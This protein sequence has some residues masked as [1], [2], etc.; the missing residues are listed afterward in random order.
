MPVKLGLNFNLSKPLNVRK[1][2]PNRLHAL[3]FSILPQSISEKTHQKAIK[4]FTT[5]FKGFF[6]GKERP[7]SR[8][9][10]DVT[11]LDDSLFPYFSQGLILERKTLSIDSV[12]IVKKRIL[13]VEHRSYEELIKD[14]EEKNDLVF[15]FKT[16]TSFKKGS[17]DY[18][19]PDPVLIFK[20]LI[21]KWNTFSHY[22]MEIPIKSLSNILQV[23]GIWIKTRKFNLSPDIKAIGFSGRVLIHINSEEKEILKSFNVL[24]QFS[25]FSGVG[26]K[27]SM[28]MGNTATI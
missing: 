22:K 7:V 12:R 28:G 16:P 11:L 20:S 17:S 3:F 8:I 9:K 15:L 18:P 6:T 13:S 1:L 27:T 25:N 10:L 21:K 4:P 19:V 26:R 23:N 24:H 14:A 2:Y 5:C